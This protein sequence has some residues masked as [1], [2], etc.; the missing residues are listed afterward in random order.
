MAFDYHAEAIRGLCREISGDS[1]TVAICLYGSRAGG[2]A[3]QDSD[4]DIAL[5]LEVYPK[6]A[7]FYYEKMNEVHAAILAVERNLF[8]LDAKT[9]ALGEFLCTRLLGPYVALDGSDILK[10]IEIQAKRRV[11]EE[12]LKDLVI[13]YG[14]I[15]RGLVID[16]TYLALSRLR[17]RA[18]HYPALLYGYVN[19]LRGDSRAANLTSILQ[20]YQVALQDLSSRGVIKYQDDK[21]V[22]GDK[23]IDEI[24]SR[25]SYEKAV[26]VVEM[27][28]RAFYS[29]LTYGRSRAR[30]IELILQELGSALQRGIQPGFFSEKAEDPRNYLFLQTSRGLVDLNERSSIVD[31]AHRL[32]PG[33]KIAITPLASVINDVYLVSVDEEQLV[34]KKYTDWFSLKWF[35][36]NLVTLGTKKFSVVGRS[37]LANEYGMNRILSAEGIAVP[38]I[39]HIS[40]PDRVLLETYV[41]GRNIGDLARLASSSDQVSAG[42]YE[43]ASQMGKTMAKIHSINVTL[44]DSKPDNFVFSTDG[45]VY[46]LD[47]EQASKRGDKAWD[48]SEFLFYSGHYSPLMSQG[49]S[50]FIDGFIEGYSEAGERSALRRAAGINYMKV[51]SLWTA[52]PVMYRIAEQL[53]RA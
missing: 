16:P 52:P 33:A 49:L 9:G 10:R 36:I 50:Q 1:P 15:S 22:L 35:T 17:K 37:R 45:K 4:F 26:N 47:L 34:A 28:R 27:S 8:E 25:R 5:V 44:G 19:M 11:I 43:V 7:G 30:N 3:R 31:V 6:G 21:I 2:Y 18:R 38:G 14:E 48:V 42:E 40:V 29:Y 23:F 20:G 32:R 12:E 13:E 51:F 41:E 46:S 24:L 39:V 53:R